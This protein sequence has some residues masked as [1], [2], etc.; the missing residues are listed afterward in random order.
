MSVLEAAR[1]A[2]GK[3]LRIAPFVAVGR[4]NGASRRF[5]ARYAVRLYLASERPRG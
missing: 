1:R 5:C 2:V 3:A 4:R